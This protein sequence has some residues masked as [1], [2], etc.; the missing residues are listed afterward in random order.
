MKILL[1]GTGAI[2]CFF[3]AKIARSGNDITFLSKGETY[4]IIK[5][6]GIKIDSDIEESFNISVNIIDKIDLNAKFDLVMIATKNYDVLSLLD[7]L[8]QSLYNS[9]CFMT[10]QNGV[11]SEDIILNRIT[12]RSLYPVSAFVGLVKQKANIVKHT[13]G[14]RFNFGAFNKS[15]SKDFLNKVNN[16]LRSSQIDV[17]L[18]E[19]I[20]RVKWGK[21]VWNAAYNPLSTIT[22]LNLGDILSSEYGIELLRSSMTETVSIANK[23][24]FDFNKDFID[25]QIN[26]PKNL[27]SF[28]TSMLQDYMANKPLEVDG[29]LGDIIN[30]AEKL[31][32]AVPTNRYFYSVIKVLLRSRNH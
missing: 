8:P 21:L 4:N 11:L 9:A 31:N 23:Y 28:K 18:S 12:S 1:I 15:G 27:Y 26:L 5:S 17:H 29:I 19:N 32:I 24:G 16:I 3:G 7:S 2:G 10:M 22:Q 20:M 14:G 25:K 13:G 6:K 30:R